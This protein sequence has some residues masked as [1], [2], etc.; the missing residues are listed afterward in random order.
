MFRLHTQAFPENGALEDS[1]RACHS[2]AM[3]L[4]EHRAIAKRSFAALGSVQSNRCL[5]SLEAAPTI[6]KSGMVP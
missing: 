6:I 4:S 5:A 1:D 2:R 3:N